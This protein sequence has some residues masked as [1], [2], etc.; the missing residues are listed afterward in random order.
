[1]W[2][3]HLRTAQKDL[4]KLQECNLGQSRE[5][6]EAKEGEGMNANLFVLAG[7]MTHE[8]LS[9]VPPHPDRRNNSGDQTCLQ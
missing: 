2:A 4:K 9:C 8:T 3:L 5:E 6:S 7:A 1:M